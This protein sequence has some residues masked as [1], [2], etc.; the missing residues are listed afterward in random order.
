MDGDLDE[1][2]VVHVSDGIGGEVGDGE[3]R[4]ELVRQNP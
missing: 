1:V 4:E 2:G 3:I